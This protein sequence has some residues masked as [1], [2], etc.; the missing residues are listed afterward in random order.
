MPKLLIR[1]L[2]QV[3]SPAGV[4]APLR[5]RALGELDL[6]ENGYVLCDGD[7]D[8]GGRSDER[9]R[10]AWTATSRTSTGRG[11]A[12]SRASSTV[13]RIRHS[14]ATASRSSRSAPAA[15][16][17]RSCTRP[18]AG[19][20]RPCARRATAGEDGLRRGRRATPRLDARRRH[21][22]VRGEVGLRPRSRDGARVVARDRGRR[23]SPDLP[24]RPRDAAGVRGRGRLSRLPARRRAPGRGASSPRQPT[25][26]SSA[27]PSTPPR[28]AATSRPAG[29]HGLALRLHGDQFTEAGAIPLA[30]ELGARSVDHLEATGPDGIAALAGERRHRRAAAGE[31]ALPRPADAAGTRARRRRAPPSRSRPTS[32]PAAPS[33]RACPS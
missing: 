5:G 13:T 30:V 21:D 15:R 22:D 33:A 19:S 28:R 23:R 27:A 29:D 18:A 3:V 2:R 16:A 25:S 26:S 8:R 10:A 4:D 6:I 14:A 31:R 1:D 20:S 11:S 17:T 32:T 24:R 12:R 7:T 9:A